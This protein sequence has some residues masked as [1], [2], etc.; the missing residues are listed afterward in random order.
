VSDAEFLWDIRDET[1]A[2]FTDVFGYEP[3]GM[4]SAPGTVNL[5][6]DGADYNLGYALSSA[7]DR[8]AFI[9]LGL[10]EDGIARVASSFSGEVVE[11]S[12]LEL[13]PEQFAGWSAFPLVVAWA[14]GQSVSLGTSGA[15]LAAVPGFDIYIESD[16]PSGAAFSAFGAV[17]SAVALA[18][19]DVWQLGLDRHTLI[20]ACQLADSV[21]IGSQSSGMTASASLLGQPD[22]A[23]FVDRRNLESTIVR[24]GIL[25]AG[26]GVLLIDTDAQL[27]EDIEID[28]RASCA[29]GASRLGVGTLRDLSV[30]DLPRARD[31]LD[32]ITF[33]RV[34]HVVT[35]NQ[36]VLDAVIALEAHDP[37]SIGELLDASHRSLRD[38]FDL[39]TRELDLAVETAQVGGAL[40]ARA[41]GSGSALALVALEDVSRIQVAIDGAFAEHALGVPETYLVTPSQGALRER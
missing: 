3:S 35:E 20:R 14:L 31:L 15:D 11:I 9:A 12:L 36:R 40:G 32:D 18:L 8:R 21:A 33:R 10:R 23:V 6:G 5:I 7:I 2:T 25:D 26:L 1:A 27:P 22:A 34:R 39:S 16:V 19:A 4:W 30:D 37:A 38:D 41:A 24:L 29:L 17:E 13:G 28:R